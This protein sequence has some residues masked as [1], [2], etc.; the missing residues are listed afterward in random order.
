M[1]VGI[2]INTLYVVAVV[3]FWQLSYSG[4]GRCFGI[5]G[6][7]DSSGLAQRKKK[8]A[9]H[10]HNGGLGPCPPENFGFQAL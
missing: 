4:V 8:R 5:G 9:M 7:G 3:I 1:D 2:N 6:L 10:A